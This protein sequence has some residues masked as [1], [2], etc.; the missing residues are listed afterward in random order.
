MKLVGTRK[1]SVTKLS[2]SYVII[3]IKRC[4]DDT[5]R[6][7]PDGTIIPESEGGD[8]ECSSDEEIKDWTEGKLLLTKIINNEAKTDTNHD[9]AYD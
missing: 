4:H 3:E 8:P 7:Y 2:Y 6:K 1:S 5:R 9:H